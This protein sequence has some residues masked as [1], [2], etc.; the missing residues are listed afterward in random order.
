MNTSNVSLI[1]S[2]SSSS[3][4]K[5]ANTPQSPS[6][7]SSSSS[8]SKPWPLKRLPSQLRILKPR[9][10]IPWPQKQSFVKLPKDESQLDAKPLHFHTHTHTNINTNTDANDDGNSDADAST[11][12]R[13]LQKKERKLRVREAEVGRREDEVRVRE[14]KVWEGL[15]EM[16]RGKVHVAILEERVKELEGEVGGG[17]KKGADV[18]ASSE[19]GTRQW[20]VK[21]W[22]SFR[23]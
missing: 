12:P 10:H 14:H 16:A 19:R 7:S 3:D 17:R 5:I 20:W 1:R 9:I 13:Y 2:S 15:K 6:S 11:T 22:W 21:G 8:S 23:E 4:G 18:G